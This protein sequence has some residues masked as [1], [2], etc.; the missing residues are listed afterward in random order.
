MTFNAEGRLSDVPYVECIWRGQADQDHSLICPADGRFNLR[1]IKR[2]GGIQVMVE[3]ALTKADPALHPE[4]ID[5]L[6]IKFKLGVFMPCIPARKL[7]DSEALL[8]QAASPRRFWLNSVAWEVPDFENIDTFVERLV[9]E[10]VLLF[11]P[12]VNAALKEQPQPASPRT[13]RHRF[14][15]T[16]GLSQ[17]YI[18]QI[19]RA[20][21]AVA[22]LEQGVPILDVVVQA[23]YADQ[24]HLT[25]SLKHFMGQTPLQVIRA[26]ILCHSVQDTTIS[27]TI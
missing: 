25:R 27:L 19:E 3:G 6:V 15:Q 5:W 10:D 4:G 11:D 8:P 1:F 9:R 26:G 18:R 24:P 14:L 20:H 2:H 13:I 17:N 23:G 7:L 22:L 21:Y 16:T 12:V